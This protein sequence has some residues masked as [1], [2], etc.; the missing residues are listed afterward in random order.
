MR[1]GPVRVGAVVVFGYGTAV[2]AY[3]L[4][5]YGLNAYADF[6]VWLGGYFTALIA[7]D[8]ASA[9]LIATRRRAGLALGSAVLVT[10]ALANWYAVYI[11]NP[12]VGTLPRIGQ[13]VT[14]ALAVGLVFASVRL[15]HS[16]R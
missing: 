16:F 2:H 7:L 5:N 14:S 9:V 4:I 8:A 6:P 12:D 10:D 15:W 13:A 1:E 3:D 11:S